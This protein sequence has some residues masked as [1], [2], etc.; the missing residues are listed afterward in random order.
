MRREA[1]DKRQMMEET[2]MGRLLWK[3]SGPSVIGI[4]A[5]NLYNVFD[6]AFVS[7]GAGTDAVG[8]VAVSF[9]LFILL[10]AV[11]STLGNGAASVISRALGKGDREKA[12]KAA[13]NTFVLFYAAAL[14]ITVFGLLWLD[15]LLHFMGVTDTLMPYA[16]TYTRIIL[17][18][19][20]TST[21]FSSLIRAEGSSRYAMY[22]WVIPMGANILLDCILIFVFRMG[23]VGAAV[24]T[25]AGQGISMAMSIYYFYISGKSVLHIRLRHFIPEAAIIG[26]V[27]G[28][29][30]P[31]FLQLSGQSAALIIVNQFLRKY[32]GDLAISSYGIANR[33]IVFFLFPIQ[34][35]SQGLQPVIGYNKGAGKPDRV[36]K[37]LY[38]ASVMSAFYG[39]AAY[40]LTVLMSDIFMRLFT[41]DPAVIETGSHILVIVNIAL[42]FTGIQNMQ[43]TY[44]QAA[45]KKIMS[46]VL[47][48]C[49]QLLCFVPAVFVLSRL[50][51]LEGVWYAFP[52]SAVAALIISSVLSKNSFLNLSKKR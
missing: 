29:G 28:I 6:T 37:A 12:A 30:I 16:R 43:T 19:A 49:G 22:I 25:V 23:V 10:S 7:W 44:F 15:E 17:L 27:T 46:L 40:L 33:I 1:E 3:M 35:I 50:Y 24:G 42:L 5:Y 48:L 13:A 32:G 38:T 14:L 45:G 2:P 21:G 18:G 31:S 39:I 36:R 41:S 52:V 8:G 26:E 9:P 47:A 4:M 11:S 51:G 20:V 34:G